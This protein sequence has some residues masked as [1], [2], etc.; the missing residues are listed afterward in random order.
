MFTY[1]YYCDAIFE[2]EWQP[3]NRGKAKSS[4]QTHADHTLSQ[5]AKAEFQE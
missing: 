1:Q 4:L 2:F 3:L 5:R